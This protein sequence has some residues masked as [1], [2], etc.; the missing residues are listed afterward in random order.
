MK[1]RISYL[2]AVMILFLM[3]AGCGGGQAQTQSAETRGEE[4]RAG[5]DGASET[6]AVKYA[7]ED[8]QA[9]KGVAFSAGSEEEEESSFLTEDLYDGIIRDDKDAEKALRS[10][11][12]RLG[13]EEDTVLEPVYIRS[14]DNGL[15][16]YIFRQLQGETSIY[17]AVVKLAADKDGHAV[18]VVSSLFSGVGDADMPETQIT[19]EEAEEIVR[20]EMEGT[21]AEVEKGVT[22]AVLL[23]YLDDTSSFYFA[24]AVYTN[25][26]YTEYETAYLVHYVD[27]EG[28]Y[29]YALPVPEPG[30]AD[31]YSGEGASLAFS[32]Y[33]QDVWSGKVD[34]RGGGTREVTIPVLRDKETGQL[35][36]GDMERGVLC[37]DYLE[38]ADNGN[39]ETRN[40]DKNGWNSEEVIV[41]DTFLRVY[42]VFE[43]TGWR[44]PDGDGTPTL[45]LMGYVDE[46]GEPA[47]NACYA[48]R[49]HGFQVFQFDTAGA[50]GECT[51]VVAHEYT[52]C[53][54][55]TLM[56]TILYYNAYGAINE[57][58]SDICG[59]L[60]EDMLGDTEDTAWLIAEHNET[61]YRC[62]SD[63]NLYRQPAHVWGLYYVP[64][65]LS[66]ND[67][68]D[69]GGVHTNSSL[70]NLIAYRLNETGMPKEDQL[71]FWMNVSMAMTPYSDYS[72]LIRLLPWC[73][74]SVGAPEY[75]DVISAAVDE[76]GI[77]DLFIP[78]TAPEGLGFVTFDFPEPETEKPYYSTVTLEGAEES[79]VTWPNGNTT[80]AAAA[81]PE[82]RYDVFAMFCTDRASE[83]LGMVILMEDGWK[84]YDPEAAEEFAD[85]DKTAVFEVLAGE[86]VSLETDGLEEAMKLVD[87]AAKAAEEAEESQEAQEGAA[88]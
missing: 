82:G 81:V 57:S 65:S 8:L 20:K 74:E 72:Q 62:M 22:E 28:S 54:T 80:T 47:R 25:N 63:P 58:F 49:Q 16:W 37:G 6:Q 14:N 33:E 4:T 7:A 30:S 86:V 51:D 73:L 50:F 21:G 60:V 13:V 70:L 78:E 77:R 75:K 24:Y 68:N 2:A 56:S 19:A 12:G 84:Y 48:G 26:I 44:G 11:F 66:P 1:K 39:I 88:A 27:M 23:P 76:T 87:Q 5:E 41:Y 38:F 64:D 79:F 55:S 32:G 34:L 3:L 42:D 59:N 85:G 71:Y 43:S 83:P 69:C 31:V 35:C 67:N 40:R 9:A 46:N 10:L 61:P 15:V 29:L 52:H 18:A 17:G 53:M 45:L 36:L